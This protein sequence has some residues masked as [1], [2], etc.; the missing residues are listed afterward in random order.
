MFMQTTTVLIRSWTSSP[1]NRLPKTKRLLAK[2]PG[3]VF[4]PIAYNRKDKN[5]A[6]IPGRSRLFCHSVHY[7]LV[8]AG[9]LTQCGA[10][11][12]QYSGEATEGKELFRVSR[13]FIAVTK[14]L[15]KTT[16]R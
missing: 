5:I 4:L 6:Q 16:E 9:N 14:H 15:R 12:I 7:S 1:I 10:I 13:V 11:M 3:S 2:S 8:N